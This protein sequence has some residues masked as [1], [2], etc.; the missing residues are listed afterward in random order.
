MKSRTAIQFK[1][2]GALTI[3]EVFIADPDTRFWNPGSQSR[4]PFFDT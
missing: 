3:D 4:R 1:V 2:G